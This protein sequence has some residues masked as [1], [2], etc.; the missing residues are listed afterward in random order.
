MELLKKAEEN[1]R[2]GEML[3]SNGKHNHSIHNFYYSVLQMMKHLVIAEGWADEKSL[4]QWKEGSHN[5]IL[6]FIQLNCRGT[7]L[8]ERDFK[9][10]FMAAKSQRNKAD[11]GLFYVRETEQNRVLNDCQTLKNLLNHELTRSK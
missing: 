6:N 7:R 8:G 1:W 9:H 4:S 3:T 11:Y 5:A 10:K 2:I